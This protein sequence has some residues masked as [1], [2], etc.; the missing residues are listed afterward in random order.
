MNDDE[1]PAATAA[2][3]AR[4]VSAF[5]ECHPYPPP[6]DDLQAY[7]QV[8]DDQRR[9][10]DSHLFWPAEPY[11]DD[12]SILV[13]G[14]GTTQAAHYALRWPRAQVIGIDV[15]DKSI[16]FTQ[17][18]KRK[19]ALDNLEVRRLAVER[20]AE[21]GR[22]FDHVVCTGVLHHLPDPDAGL[23]ARRDAL[24]PAGALHIMVYAPYGR[25]G[26]Y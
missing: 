18:L 15:S 20:A 26:V 11:R 9:R 19:H 6:V 12:R 7:R 5:Y 24:E 13:A 2:T 3:I 10:A 17:E 23:R 25:A 4:Q 22:A 8:W 21:L 1:V 16:A 14:C